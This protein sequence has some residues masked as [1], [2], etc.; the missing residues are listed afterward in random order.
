MKH[1]AFCL[2]LCAFSLTA[3]CQLSGRWE[4]SLA[5][6]PAPPGPSLEE[7]TLS[8]TYAIGGGWSVTSTTEFTSLGL[9]SQSFGLLGRFGPVI[10]A[11]ELDFNPQSTDTVIVT[12]PNGCSPQTEAVTLTAPAYKSAWL[13][14][15][16][17]FAGLEVSAEMQHWTFPYHT[18]DNGED[19]EGEYMWPCCPPQTGSY[20]LITLQTTAP[21]VTLAVRFEDCCSGIAFKDVTITLSD[22]SLCCGITYDAEVVFTKLG[23][24]YT[25]FTL[26]IPF[27]C[28]I[29]IEASAKFTVSAKAVNLTPKWNGLGQACVE[30]YGDVLWDDVTSTWLGIAIYGYKIRCEFAQCRFVELLT[31]LDVAE[32]EE[33]LDDEDLFQG[34]E[35]EYVKLGFCGPGCCGGTYT[36]TVSVYFQP[37]GSLFGLSRL[38]M[39]MAIPVLANFI[40]TASVAVDVSETTG[41][42]MGWIFTF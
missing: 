29:A 42:K 4:S 18:E 8:L 27:C 7:T 3:A 14:S 19:S 40:L 15:T 35:F 12:Y 30:V 41:F 10:V 33:A 9:T 16:L 23:F 37:A 24:G 28:G 39:D 20:T 11:G 32:V 36:L 38:K 22:A 6:L 34:D 5:I 31:A 25:E 1:A 13:S 2:A 26:E 21:P 17:Q